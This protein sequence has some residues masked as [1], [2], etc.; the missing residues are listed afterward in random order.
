MILA[1]PGLFLGCDPTSEIVESEIPPGDFSLT[2]LKGLRKYPLGENLP[3]PTIV[4]QTVFNL[5]DVNGTTD[6]YFLLRNIGGSTITGISI[7]V[8]DSSF[9]VFPTAIDSLSPGSALTLEQLGEIPLVR[10]S[11]IHGFGP[12]QLMSAGPHSANLEIHGQTFRED[13]S[14]QEIDLVVR[15]DI[16][17]LLMDAVVWDGLT[18]VDLLDSDGGILVGGFVI[19]DFVPT[20]Q[21]ADTARIQ[22]TG[23]VPLYLTVFAT[24]LEDTL[25]PGD[26]LI[27]DYDVN[28]HIR[29]SSGGIVRD[30][31]RFPTYSDGNT[32]IYLFWEW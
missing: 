31:S 8:S 2:C 22:N 16:N 32:Y 17:A 10:V 26:W 30:L 3:D 29:F 15:I 24:G 20:Y 23:N 14:A 11:A 7:S 6:F 5:G 25:S 18:M 28:T 13:G 12:L 27:L 4:Q 9:L 19:T 1:L 21:I